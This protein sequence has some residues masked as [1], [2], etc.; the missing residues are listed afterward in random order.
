[1]VFNFLETAEATRDFVSVF[2]V[3]EDLVS[4]VFVAGDFNSGGF[5][6]TVD[7][8]SG[9]FVFED[10]VSEVFVA[11]D[12]NSGGFIVEDTKTNL[13]GGVD[14][15]EVEGSPEEG[16]LSTISPFDTAFFFKVSR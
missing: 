6:V 4:G 15:F 8:V 11:G 5:M 14:H 2:F 9:V 12:F 16:V 13:T 7:L 1:M 3:F 10:L